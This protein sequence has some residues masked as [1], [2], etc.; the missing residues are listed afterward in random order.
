MQLLYK[1]LLLKRS[2][3]CK[4]IEKLDSHH[5]KKDLLID[6]ATVISLTDYKVSYKK[7]RK[8]F[9]TNQFLVIIRIYSVNSIC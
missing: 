7:V 6:L 2:L 8:S 1:I 3:E 5:K 4:S 9:K